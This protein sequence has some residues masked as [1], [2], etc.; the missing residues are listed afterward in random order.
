LDASQLSR[1]VGS[2]DCSCTVW[3][4]PTVCWLRTV[5][6]GTPASPA[7]PPLL[8]P[9]AAPAFKAQEHDGHV[10]GVGDSMVVLVT[11]SSAE[12]TTSE[13]SPTVTAPRM[14][15]THAN[16]CGLPWYSISSYSVVACGVTRK[17]IRWSVMTSPLWVCIGFWK[18]PPHARAS[19]VSARVESALEPRTTRRRPRRM[20][21]DLRVRA[22][23]T[24]RA[25][26]N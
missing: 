8:L 13:L 20:I 3:Y 6:G 23:S 18:H 16:D 5:T 11:A 4:G 24:P 21:G 2:V 12:N 14:G 9:P 7:P 17:T 1:A 19:E 25:I 22:S 15:S 10:G 26:R